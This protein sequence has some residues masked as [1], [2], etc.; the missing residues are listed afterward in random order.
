MEKVMFKNLPIKRKIMV[1]LL[2]T[3]GI[4]TIVSSAIVINRGSNLVEQNI[5]SFKSTMIAQKKKELKDKSEIITNIVKSYYKK[6]L[7]Q[8][9]EKSVKNSLDKRMD[10]LFNILNK[11]YD[12]SKGYINQNNLQ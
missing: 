10:L 7:P 6:T 11:T 3:M 1:L 9:M 4:L 12:K 5:K 8:E 2:S